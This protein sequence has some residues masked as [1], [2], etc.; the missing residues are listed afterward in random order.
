MAELPSEIFRR[1][2]HSF[3]EDEGDLKVYRPADYDFPRARGRPGF[4]FRP[5]GSFVDWAI[6]PADAL[7]PAEV[8]WRAEAA[9]RVRVEETPASRVF[10]IVEIGP[11]VLKLR[12]T[13]S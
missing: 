4:E 10:E 11:D 3:E 5:D 6:G 8:R 1:W 9:N 12:E 7:Q 2:G 13:S